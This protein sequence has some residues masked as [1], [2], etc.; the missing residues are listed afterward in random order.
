[1]YPG[2]WIR[3]HFLRIRIQQFFRM[4]IRIQVQI[5]K[6]CKKINSWRV[7]NNCKNIKDCS[8]VGNNEACA[9]LLLKNWM[10]L[11]LLAISLHFFCFYMTNFPS[12]IHADPDPQPW[13]YRYLHK[14]WWTQDFLAVTRGWQ[15]LRIVPLHSKDGFTVVSKHGRKF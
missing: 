10:H 14:H 13:T 8:K 3:I 12:W 9:N 11:Q 6:I 15:M 2:L 7:F 5:D 4:R 1:M